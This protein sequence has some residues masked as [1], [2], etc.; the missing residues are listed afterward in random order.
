MVLQSLSD[1]FEGRKEFSGNNCPGKSCLIVARSMRVRA[2]ESECLDGRR[3]VQKCI[4]SNLYGR[5]I[6]ENVALWEEMYREVR[7]LVWY[8]PAFRLKVDFNFR[9]WEEISWDEP[10]GCDVLRVHVLERL[11]PRR[12]I[13]CDLSRIYDTQKFVL[14]IV[15][16]TCHHASC[17]FVMEN[18]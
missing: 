2:R 15:H 13:C 4:N 7:S 10:L 17:Y 1:F 3:V 18:R 14:C 8:V 9:S 16:A 12:F 11:V 5:D 6:W